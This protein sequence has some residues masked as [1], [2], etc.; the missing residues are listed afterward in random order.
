MFE[1]VIWYFMW[2]MIG[3]LLGVLSLGFAQMHD[4]KINK[5]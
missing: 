3:W 5:K 2:V 1:T 4:E